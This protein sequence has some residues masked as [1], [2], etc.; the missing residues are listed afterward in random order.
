MQQGVNRLSGAT[1][2][3]AAAGA[4]P[5]YQWLL[6]AHSIQALAAYRQHLID[7]GLAEAGAF[8]QAALSEETEKTEET[9]EGEEANGAAGGRAVV[10]ELSQ[11]EFLERLINTKRPQYFA[12]SAVY[13]DGRDWNQTEL[14]LLGDLGVAVPVWVFDDG[15]HHSP[16]LHAQPLDA[17]L[18][19][20]SGALLRNGRGCVPADW[21][22]VTRDR[23]LDPAGYYALYARRLQPLLDYVNADALARGQGAV[24]TI[25]GLGC[26]QF[27]GP[28]AGT[29]GE[30]LKKALMALLEQQAEHLPQ[31]RM[32]YYDPYTECSNQRHEFG[33]LSLLVRPLLQGNADKTQLCPPERYAEPGDDLSHCRLYSLVAWDPVSWPGNDF[34]AGARITDD[35]VKAAASDL[36]RAITGV[37]GH[38]DAQT[39]GYQPP[40]PYANWEA[41]AQQRQTRLRFHQ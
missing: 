36:M 12:E 37:E 8:L 18:L 39:H 13:G 22:A 3:S 20:I 5:A 15:R 27:A 31:I 16:A 19:F 10:S 24:I 2:T 40:A 29:L 41:L 7:N 4:Q 11:A 34:W 23:Q 17:T 35:G 6:S 1:L 21:A 33:T 32:I 25:P 30:S 26:G 9:K 14:S 28:F 38:Y